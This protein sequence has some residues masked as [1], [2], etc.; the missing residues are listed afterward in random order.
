[1]RCWIMYTTIEADILDGVVVSKD[2]ARF[3]KS[4]RVLITFIDN[5]Q[6]GPQK[7][8]P[9]WEKIQSNLDKLHLRVDTVAWQRELRN[10]WHKS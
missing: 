6:D 2:A 4:A 3:P 8:K 5:P 9:D 1:M 10:E 7:R